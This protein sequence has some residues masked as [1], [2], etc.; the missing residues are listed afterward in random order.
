MCIR[1]SPETIDLKPI[2]AERIEIRNTIGI[3]YNGTVY[4]TIKLNKKIAVENNIFVRFFRYCCSR[5]IALSI[6]EEGPN[7]TLSITD[8]LIN[9]DNFYL[10]YIRE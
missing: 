6:S 10:Q 1:D 9:L 4:K 5:S 7:P 8:E 2:T 3:G